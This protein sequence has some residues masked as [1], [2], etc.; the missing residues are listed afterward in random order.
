MYIRPGNT[1]LED[2]NTELAEA[3]DSYAIKHARLP[4]HVKPKEEKKNVNFSKEKKELDNHSKEKPISKVNKQDN[5][6]IH[7]I[8]VVIQHEPQHIQKIRKL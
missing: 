5:P 8:Q 4:V 7:A 2:I 1:P 3:F 6:G